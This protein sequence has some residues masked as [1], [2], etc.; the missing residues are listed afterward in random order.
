MIAGHLLD[1]DSH[2]WNPFYLHDKVMN[3][4]ETGYMAFTWSNTTAF[5]IYK[6]IIPAFAI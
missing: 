4:I 2:L 1:L 6:Q 3:Q 5:V